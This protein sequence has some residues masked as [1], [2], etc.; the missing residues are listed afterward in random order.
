MQFCS[1][2]VVKKD[3]SYKG[4]FSVRRKIRSIVMVSMPIISFAIIVKSILVDMIEVELVC[5]GVWR[6]SCLF[7]TRCCY[8]RNLTVVDSLCFPQVI[9]I[10]RTS[11]YLAL[12]WEVVGQRKYGPSFNQDG[13]VACRVFEYLEVVDG[14]L[15]FSDACFRSLIA[16]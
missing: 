11:V 9:Y 5:V 2:M 10:V 7:D 15:S 6:D 8:V 12:T 1:L 13:I 16:L 3:S 4:S 14:G